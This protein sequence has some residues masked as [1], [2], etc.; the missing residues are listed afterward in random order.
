MIL[1]HRWVIQLLLSIYLGSYFLNTRLLLNA[2][3]EEASII[4]GCFVRPTERKNSL[5]LHHYY[6]YISTKFK[7]YTQDRVT[8]GGEIGKEG[9][10]LEKL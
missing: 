10:K 2:H 8:N 5:F 3:R 6:W 1:N 7:E 4:K 9:T